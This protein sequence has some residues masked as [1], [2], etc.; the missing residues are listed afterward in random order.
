MWAILDIHV[1]CF[2]PSSGPFWTWTSAW[3]SLCITLHYWQLL[4][5]VTA[6]H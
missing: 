3:H 6:R 5:W 2:W 4:K 1:D